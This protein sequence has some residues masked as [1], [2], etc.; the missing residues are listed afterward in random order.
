MIQSGPMRSRREEEVEWRAAAA[1][2]HIPPEGS[3][4]VVERPG[5]AVEHGGFLDG[6]GGV[7]W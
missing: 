2:A 7:E 3:H 1:I 6:L 5:R 4:E